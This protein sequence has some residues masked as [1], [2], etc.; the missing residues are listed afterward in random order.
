MRFVFLLLALFSVT[1]FSGELRLPDGQ[2]VEYRLVQDD[3][4]SARPAALAI[5]RHLA[6][7]D[8]E[9]AALASNAP[10]RRYEV[11]HDYRASVGADEFK[12]V[13]AQ[14]LLPQNHV[15]AEIAVGPRRAILWRLGDANDHLAA[16]YFVEVD[17]RFLMDD[18]PSAERSALEKVVQEYR[19]RDGGR[20]HAGPATSP[21]RTD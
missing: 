10:R 18:V 20:R 9:E 19:Q 3:K 5:V 4:E 14:Y 8:I 15:V 17:G 12:R 11:L 6:A 2:T 7:G 16:Q 1:G 21:G 13:Y